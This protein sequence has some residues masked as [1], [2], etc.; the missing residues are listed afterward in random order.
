MQIQLILAAEELIRKR[1]MA[2]AGMKFVETLQC[3]V[4]S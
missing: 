3:I 1:A 2:Q 4:E